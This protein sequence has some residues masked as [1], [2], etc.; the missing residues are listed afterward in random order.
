M[1][2]DHVLPSSGGE[3][4]QQ[5]Y[6]FTIEA[7][8]SD[9]IDASDS[10]EEVKYVK[11]TM[12]G[13]T[14]DM[15]H[16]ESRVPLTFFGDFDTDPENIDVTGLEMMQGDYTIACKSFAINT[17]SDKTELLE[18]WQTSFTVVDCGCAPE[19]DCPFTPT[20]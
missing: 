4:C 6:S 16:F 3:L 9:C 7:N 20:E 8:L 10:Y 15:K 12:A 1:K 18:E 11:L 13:P 14:V 2:T 5:P 19:V 17:S